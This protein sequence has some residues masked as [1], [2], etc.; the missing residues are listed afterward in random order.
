MTYAINVC[1]RL[2]GKAVSIKHDCFTGRRSKH[3][4]LPGANHGPARGQHQAGGIQA[5]GWAPA[6][7][8]VTIA[9]LVIVYI[10]LLLVGALIVESLEP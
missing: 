9:W 8:G 3:A 6:G 10:M 7:G 4:W 2:P 5:G 1:H